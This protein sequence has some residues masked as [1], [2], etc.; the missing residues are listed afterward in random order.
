MLHPPA[1]AEQMVL[2][3]PPEDDNVIWPGGE[4]SVMGPPSE[5]EVAALA[6]SFGLTDTYV[7][8]TEGY[9]EAL[10]TVEPLPAP[11]Q[12]LGPQML[13][14]VQTMVRGNPALAMRL[15]NY[16]YDDRRNDDV[17][18]PIVFHI[19]TPEEIQAELKGWH[20]SVFVLCLE[21][22]ELF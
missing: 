19:R 2:A 15:S 18:R 13:K 3:L 8:D 7:P 5:E 1:S 20:F 12:P 10:R 6:A 22:Y 11:A 4:Q 16:I 9:G 17:N 21:F 14:T